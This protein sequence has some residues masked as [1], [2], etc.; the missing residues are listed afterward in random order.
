MFA[1]LLK[2]GDVVWDLGANAGIFTLVASRIVGQKGRVFAFE[3]QPRN[4]DALRRHLELNGFRN[5][6]VWPCAVSDQVGEA[7]FDDSG[8]SSQGFLSDRG[9]IVV[10]TVTLDSLMATGELLAPRVIKIDIEGAEHRA[11]R[12]AERTIDACRPAVFLATH[13]VVVHRE[14]CDWLRSRDYSL[15]PIGP[16]HLEDADEILAVPGER[17]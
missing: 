9:Q 6:D 4:V 12:G 11:L 15:E 5:V 3:P 17:V 16:T 7:R 10:P 14:C 2:N 13:G 1:A 8:G